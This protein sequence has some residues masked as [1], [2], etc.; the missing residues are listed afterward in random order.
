MPTTG[1]WHGRRAGS[2]RRASVD[3]RRPWCCSRSCRCRDFWTLP[4]NL[5]LI[6][7][8]VVLS[9]VVL[10]GWLGQVSLAQ[11]A[12]V[13]VGGAGVAIGS[14]HARPAVPV[15]ASCGVLLSIPVSI[16]IGLPALRLR[17]LH[18]A[19]AT[20]AFGLA[21]ERAILPRFYASVYRRGSPD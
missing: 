4:A 6:Y 21:A 15:A 3:L 19:V 2:H 7:L 1:S 5:T 20:L 16:L 13:A 9:F 11:G 14:Q 12:F 8:L 10:V 17:G 18:L